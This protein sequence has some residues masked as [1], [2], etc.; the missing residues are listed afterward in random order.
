M[1]NKTLSGIL[2]F[3][4]S[5]FILCNTVSAEET[6]SLEGKTYTDA[7]VMEEPIVSVERNGITAIFSY[8]D[9]QILMSKQVGD[10]RTIYLVE[11]GVIKA[12]ESNNYT[13]EYGYTEIYGELRCTEIV[14]EN[15]AY[16]LVYDEWGNVAAINDGENCIC[17]YDYS[18][19]Q[20]LPTVY[21]MYMGLDSA[22]DLENFIGN[23]NPFRYQG[24]YLDTDVNCYY[25][26][27]GI[28]YDPTLQEFIQNEY[29]ILDWGIEWLASHASVFSLTSTQINNI[30]NQ[31][32]SAMN[33][34]LYGAKT[35]S[36]VSQ[37][38]WNNG[39]R[40]YDGAS[41][42]EVIARCIWAE[43]S[44][45]D[46]GN[47]R[48]GIA[49]VIMN[50]MTSKGKSGYDVVTQ[51]AQFS[52][53]NPATYP[54]ESGTINTR[55][56]KSKTNEAWQQA[57][58]LACIILYGTE[59]DDINY[60][61]TLPTGIASQLNFRGLDYLSTLSFDGSNVT[62]G[63]SAK[64]DVAIAGY[65]YINSSSS[66]QYLVGLKGNHYTLFYND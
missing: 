19:N 18:E 62:I 16:S 33:N 58:M 1:K 46:K 2:I 44:Y 54:G 14:W 10:V 31:Y 42:L 15:K 53:V 12:V 5:F 49:A 47:D 40:W 7:L 59:R 34:G 11:D 43:S 66:Y 8:S 39:K 26:G 65:G 38:E 51:R 52:T 21:N 55:M 4:S 56:A 45:N 60:F 20:M 25:L 63:G 64:K 23:I 48:I 30:V 32:N 13:I 22:S 57:T 9:E 24:W 37:T 41:Q 61:Y 29:T 36:E 17:Q 28:F 27:D 35:Y 3:L 6:D 50:R